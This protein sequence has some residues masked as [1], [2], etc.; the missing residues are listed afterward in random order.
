VT[1]NFLP[2]DWWRWNLVARL[3]LRLHSPLVSVVIAVKNG[4][5]H[6]RR[7]MEALER[8]TYRNFEVIVQD[9]VSTDG[10]LEYLRSLRRLPRIDIVSEPDS[11][12]GQAY[13]RGLRRCAGQYVW[14]SAADEWLEHDAL[15]RAL[16]WRQRWPR[17][18]VIFGGIRLIDA[19]GRVA[20][21]FIPPTFELEKFLAQETSVPTSTALLD[22]ARMG[23]AYYLDET[24][25]TCPDFDLW[26]R[27]CAE[28]GPASLVVVPEVVASA[29][30]DETSM[31]YCAG[32]FD[33]FVR[34]K[35]FIL[36]RHLNGLKDPAEAARLRKAGRAGIFTWA[37]EQVFHIEGAR[38]PFL[39]WCELAAELDAAGP[40][41]RTLERRSGA[42]CINSA[43]G[44]AVAV[45]HPDAP[46]GHVAVLEGVVD[47]A[48]IRVEKHWVGAAVERGS[49]FRVR[50]VAAS[51]GY[52]ATIPIRT[53]RIE[54]WQDWHWIRL[55]VHVRQG[56]AGFGIIGAAGLYHEELVS[57]SSSPVD[58]WLRLD[59]QDSQ[60]VM[61]R[62]GSLSGYS[63]AVILAASAA[64]HE[65]RISENG[66]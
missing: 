54:N 42:F 29:L 50:T 21:E 56:Q 63:M 12:I 22:R 57:A 51:W 46:I 35:L 13:A 26:I 53:D 14:M 16:L 18:A 58:V 36:D 15:E 59:R 37:A 10:S 27:V 55:T 20:G 34:D 39:K 7:S 5:P 60:A 6:L 8:Q 25:R 1:V 2:T 30:R 41:L 64:R 24:L 47:I 44:F 45:R 33:A 28:Y 4:M 38:E 52:S 48:A 62:N 11:G 32:N 31:S 23:S 40:R 49:T 61:V 66:N 9:G 43:G 65:N 17:A 3:R 19:D